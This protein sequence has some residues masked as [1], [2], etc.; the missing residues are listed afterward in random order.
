MEQFPK[1][2]VYEINMKDIENVANSLYVRDY[3]LKDFK[4]LSPDVI[5][6]KTNK[7][8]TKVET[9]GFCKKVD[10]R[11]IIRKWFNEVMEGWKQFLYEGSLHGVKYIFEPTFSRKERVTWIIIVV[12]SIFICTGVIIQ[13]FS[14]SSSTPFVNVID[15]LPTPIWAVP[16][17][18]VVICPHLHVQLSYKNVTELEDLQK[19]FA[20]RICPQM[21]RDS[22]VKEGRLSSDEIHMLQDFIV[23]AS[24]KCKDVVKLCHW[25]SIDQHTHWKSE[26]CCDTFF[27]SIFTNY[28]LCFT[29]NSL[30]LNGMS[31][32]TIHW[33]QSFSPNVTP[34][35]IKWNLDDGYPKVFPPDQTTLPFRVMASGETNGL[36]LDLFLNTSEHQFACDGS[37]IGFNVIIRSPTDHVYTST[38]L[39]LPME[40]MTTIEVNPITYK[41]DANLRQLSPDRR[42]CFFQNERKLFYYEFYTDSNC[43]FDLL[44]REAVKVCKCVLYNWPRKF[45]SDPVCSTA[46]DFNCINSVKAK[47]EEQLI[48]AYYDD[49]EEQRKPKSTSTSCH[50][51]CN[52]FMYSSQV[53]YSD[54]IKEPGNEAPEWGRPKP[55]EVTR[56]NVHFYEDMFLGQ[57]RHAQYDDYYFIGAIGGLLSLFL[58]F[59]IISVAELL[60]FVVLRPVHAALKE[61]F[62]QP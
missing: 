59:S 7:V 20:S 41:T 4:Y 25:R 27:K 23:K 15:S 10:C 47:V 13:L 30:P 9:D 46:V 37:S 2:K 40:R 57:H 61:T 1:D 39:R 49:S 44:L 42:Q 32:E 52:D 22:I 24:P 3:Y 21:M 55:G 51:S 8:F 58:G 45:V 35:K 38:V 5:N 33:Q 14:K 34:A 26:E 12:I 50:P 60:Y 11:H 16:F 54:L 31:N 18:S 17:P 53:F 56:M 28:G 29:F 43:K 62:C 19:F 48:Y 6:M 36:G